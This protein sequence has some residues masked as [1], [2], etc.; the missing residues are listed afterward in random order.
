MLHNP[1]VSSDLDSDT[2]FFACDFETTT[3]S[4]AKDHTKVWSFAV[5]EIGVFDPKIYGSIDDFWSFCENPFYGV[6]KRLYF[7]NLKFDGEFILY[8]ALQKGIKTA[9]IDGH[10]LKPR[11]LINNEMVYAISDVGQW[12]FIAL[13]VNNILVEIRDSLKILPMTLQQVGKSFCKKY[14][15][16]E[17]NY[18]NKSSLNDCTPKDLDYIKND[19]LVLSEALDNILQLHGQKSEFGRVQSLTIGGACLQHFKQTVYG[20]IKNIQIKLEEEELDYQ[21][22]GVHNMDQYIRRGYRGGYCYVNP[23]FKGKE[24]RKPGFTA[25]VNSL[26][27]FAMCSEYSGFSL[28]YGKGHFVKGKPEEKYILDDSYYF[29][30]RLRVSFKL[31]KGYVP[32]IQVKN[33]FMYS[34]HE[35]LTTSAV[36]DPKTEKPIGDPMQIEI[37]LSKDDFILFTEHYQILTI[38]YLDYI[39]FRTAKG[40]CD[41][42]IK[43]FEKVKVEATETGDKGRRTLAKMFSNNIYGQFSKSQNSS[44]KLAELETDGVHYHYMEEENKKPVNI[45]IGAS[46][47]A[48]A[49]FYQIRTIQANLERFIYSDTDSLHCIGDP[50]EFKGRIHDSDYGAYKIEAVWNRAKFIRQ[51]TYIEELM[52]PENQKKYCDPC[53]HHCNWNICC[54][55]M[56]ETQKEYF[57]KNHKFEDF[58]EGLVIH[59]GKLLPVR[60]PGGVILQ[61]VDFTLK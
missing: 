44:F 22:T 39:L 48:H 1:I 45:A 25:D 16:T 9:C 47:T 4:I 42:Y 35:Y 7:H 15:K 58:K 2:R 17:M 34:Q 40:I 46:I 36:H 52:I 57:R 20:E 55:G 24:I 61:D 5:D 19:V 6:K 18:D 53:N 56:T 13:R 27:P 28:P 10:M 37:T 21:E 33:S 38:E 51:K 11:Q 43:F 31:K 26:Y 54:A 14:Q 12:Y 60:V 49:R 59:G 50:S 32:T 30:I 29:Y 41:P 3:A 23:R 8:S